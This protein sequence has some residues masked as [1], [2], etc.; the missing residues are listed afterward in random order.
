[1][2]SI[3]KR[4]RLS[5]LKK[6]EMTDQD[7]NRQGQRQEGMRPLSIV[8]RARGLITVWEQMQREEEMRLRRGESGPL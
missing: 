1:M 8:G 5:S 2:A 6:K 3:K 4:L 7:Q